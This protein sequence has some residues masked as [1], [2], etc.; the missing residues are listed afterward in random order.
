MKNIIYFILPL[1]L[2]FCFNFN[3]YTAYALP[4]DDVI[5]IVD[6]LMEEKTN[7]RKIPNATVSI[8]QD[9]N[10][11][12]EKGYGYVNYDN[13]TPVDSQTTLFRP[14]SISKLFT[15]TAVMQLVEQGKLDLD[16]DV[17]KY[18]DFEIPP[19]EES[20]PITLRHLMTHT[21]GLEDYS[22]ELF[23]LEKEKL[24]PLDVY[25]REFLPERIFP[26]GEVIAYSNYGTAL[27]GYIV[28]ETSG[29]PFAQY[30]KENIFEKL[31]M[32]YSTFEQPVPD[33]LQ[34]H[35][36]TAYRYVDGEYKE[37]LFEYIIE[38]AGGMST[39]ASDM[40]K[41]MIAFL[42]NGHYS[43][44]TILQE[45]TVQKMF[46]QQFTHHPT[47][48]GMGL[49]F[50]RGKI[51]DHDVFYHEGSTLLFNAGMYLIPEVNL[52][53]YI[54]YS[55]GD[56]LLHKEV[57]QQVMDYYFPQEET[58]F[59]QTSS[60]PITDI[61]RYEGEYQQNRRSLTTED[62]LLSLV[63]GTIQVKADKEGYLTVSQMGEG[64]KYY[65]IEPGV[66]KSLQTDGT[67]DPYGYFETIVF[68]EDYAGNM[69]LIAD[70]PMPFT[71]APIYATSGINFLAVGLSLLIII[72]SLLALVFISIIRKLK[73]KPIAKNRQLT[74]ANWIAIFYG[75]LLLIL[76][77]SLLLSGNDPVYQ[78][79]KDAYGMEPAWTS[80]L[81]IFPYL[82]FILTGGLIIL[83][84]ILWKNKIGKLFTRIHYTIY[85]SV[86]IF[87]VWF[88][89]YW[90][91]V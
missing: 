13:M 77:G 71:K 55:G 66:F 51:N 24:L 85:T 73:K 82:M 72:G 90:N 6:Q 2:F 53:I 64:N 70:G 48:N 83:T 62:K 33:Y 11:I 60:K 29:M 50:V 25:V 4:H 61:K 58:T 84:A 18:I 89:I 34:E 69:L 45:E 16:E 3:T 30:I 74:L 63:I 10:I 81:N 41:F 31:G 52:G 14:G 37:A 22:M 54:A 26:A 46:Q 49:G 15:W 57:L 40:A 9:G 8:V 76:I 39:S 67:L 44:E 21:P 80:V 47:L 56:F 36:V 65:E 38:A 75:L 43:G 23:K 7:E 78:L 88:F 32:E 91:L 68:Q 87:Y 35:V 17:N 12:F 27:A 79:P 28:E 59:S 20:G 86:A 42:Q 19:Y 5:E 1:F